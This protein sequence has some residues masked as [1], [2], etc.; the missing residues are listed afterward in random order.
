VIPASTLAVT[1]SSHAAGARRVSVALTM[2]YEMQCGW[3]GPGVLVI[4][5]PASM[6]VPAHLAASAVLVDRK[7]P[8]SVA[9]TGGDSISVGLPA[10]PQILCDVIGPGTLTVTFAPAAELGNPKSAGSYVVRA[11]HASD[12]ASGRIRI[13]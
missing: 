12:S 10:R 5:L 11:T 6:R 4:R 1:L 8:A 3:P 9:V 13:T 7:P 2:H